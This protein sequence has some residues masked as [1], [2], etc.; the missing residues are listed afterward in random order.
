MSKYTTEVRY[1]CEFYA[2]LDESTDYSEIDKTIDLAQEHIFSEYPI[3]DEQYRSLLNKKI[4][5]HY[6][7]REI[8][9]ETL[10]LWKLRLNARMEEIMPYYNKLYESEL[11][12]FNPFYDVDLHTEHNRSENTDSNG[13]STSEQS[14]ESTFNEN[15]SRN[16]SENEERNGTD[17]R[18]RNGNTSGTQ[19]SEVSS[20]GSNTGKES[21]NSSET[22]ATD[23]KTYDRYSDTPQGGLTGIESNTYLTN[24]RIT[25][26]ENNNEKI[27]TD[28]R[29]T[30]G[31]N[32][33]NEERN[34][35]NIENRSEK[36]SGENTLNSERNAE[37]IGTRSGGNKNN[38]S[39]ERND[40]NHIGSIEAYAER[41]YGKRG[42]ASYA[43]MLMEFRETF[44]N[45]DK[46]IIDELSDL[47]FGLWE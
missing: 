2:G 30:E 42:F 36:E 45:I 5:R 47:F 34:N 23:N 9:E 41:V 20:S 15:D 43:K 27:G 25:E 8:C 32:E 19:S 40:E 29:T 3:F 24:A 35:E 31:Q 22:N 21:G 16:R 7:T 18:E 10:G 39:V 12:H 38:G 4:L 13:T 26:G 17:N 37:E 33:Y 14:N 28:N 46:M 6:Y 11:L 44:L 1:I